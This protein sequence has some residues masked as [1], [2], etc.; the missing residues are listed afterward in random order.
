MQHECIETSAEP[1]LYAIPGRGQADHGAVGTIYERD[2]QLWMGSYRL[3]R[4]S[5]VLGE[6][7]AAELA[8]LRARGLRPG[9][10]FDIVGHVDEAAKTILVMGILPFGPSN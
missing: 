10:R 9:E 8:R 2:G 4:A 3:L 7:A 5:G 1:R 6:R